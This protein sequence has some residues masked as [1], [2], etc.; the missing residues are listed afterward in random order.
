MNFGLVKKDAGVR[1]L[2]NE[3]TRRKLSNMWGRCQQVRVGFEANTKQPRFGKVKRF[4]C[5]GPGAYDL[6]NFVAPKISINNGFLRGPVEFNTSTK[7]HCSYGPKDCCVECGMT[8]MSSMDY[9]RSKQRITL[10]GSTQSASFYRQLFFRRSEDIGPDE[11][12][13]PAETTQRTTEK[14]LGKKRRVLICRPCYCKAMR[15]ESK[16]WKKKKDVQEIFE[17]TRHCSYTHEHNGFPE[18]TEKASC[19]WT[20]NLRRK[21]ATLTLHWPD[22]CDRRMVQK[23]SSKFKPE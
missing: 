21:E 8:L 23:R 17:K 22:K 19:L 13:K 15:G 3:D 12:K 1:Q 20:R 5:V 14:P 10:N 16:Y 7:L 4:N 9:Y 2:R 18:F 11:T 6:A